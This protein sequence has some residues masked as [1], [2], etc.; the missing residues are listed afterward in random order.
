MDGKDVSPPKLSIEIGSQEDR[1]RVM[2]QWIDSCNQLPLKMCPQD[3]FV[4]REKVAVQALRTADLWLLTD[5]TNPFLAAGGRVS[6]FAC[7]W[8]FPP[9]SEY[10]VSSHEPFAEKTYF[11]T[12]GK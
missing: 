8:V 12:L 1:L 2:G 10:I 5:A 11:V 4:Q 9:A 7:A 3:R 6:R